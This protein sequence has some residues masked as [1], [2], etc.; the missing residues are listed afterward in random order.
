[1]T[2]PYASRPDIDAIGEEVVYPGHPIT[3][4]VIILHAYAGHL[5][6][7]WAR[8]EHGWYHCEGHMNTPT[9]GGALSS[10]CALI[11]H[12]IEGRMSTDEAIAWGDRTWGGAGGHPGMV[13]Q[14]QDQA[15][16]LKPRLREMLAAI[17]PA[18]A[19]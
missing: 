17:M 3:C 16:R 15:D 10:G 18:E 8:T 4:A 2:N 6:D 5:S 7:A 9:A 11:Q 12:V 14:G 13:K 19:M 1:M